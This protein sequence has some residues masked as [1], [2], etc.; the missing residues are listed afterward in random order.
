MYA[1]FGGQLICDFRMFYHILWYSLNKNITKGYHFVKT[2]THFGGQLFLVFRM[3]YHIFWYSCKNVTKGSSFRED[4]YTFWWLTHLGFSDVLS[5][6][7]IFL[8]KRNKRIIISWRC[9]HIL[10]AGSFGIFGCLIIFYYIP[11]KHNKRVIISWRRM[12]I[13]LHNFSEMSCFA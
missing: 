13:F 11:E 3:F 1:H 4:V 2:Y 6:F 7:M 12:H 8:Q 10:E 5:H 9:M